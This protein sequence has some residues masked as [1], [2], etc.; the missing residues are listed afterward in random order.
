[1]PCHFQWIRDPAQPD[2]AL[3]R[4]A[5]SW[6]PAAVRGRGRLASARIARATCYSRALRGLHNG[7]AAA[8][9]AGVALR[10]PE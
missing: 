5:P 6:H 1:M 8:T 2:F 9:R 3:P 10:Y 4:A 7:P